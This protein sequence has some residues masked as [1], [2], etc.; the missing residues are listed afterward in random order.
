MGYSRKKIENKWTGGFS[1]KWTGLQF[2]KFLERKIIGFR[3]SGEKTEMLSVKFE[4]LEE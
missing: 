1:S 4:N 2:V 3:I